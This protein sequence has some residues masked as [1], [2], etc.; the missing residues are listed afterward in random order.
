MRTVKSKKEL[1]LDQLEEVL[2][3]PEDLQGIAFEALTAARRIKNLRAYCKRVQIFEDRS[4]G[5]VSL[6]ACPPNKEGNDHSNFGEL[7]SEQ[8]VEVIPA[9]RTTA[10]SDVGEEILR[11]LDSAA[12]LGRARGK[13]PRRGQQ[14]VAAQIRREVEAHN[15]N[16]GEMGQGALFDFDGGGQA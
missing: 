8:R 6:D 4:C 11:T 5:A 3:L 16:R 14:I 2:T 9:S 15:F 7:L 1:T 13:T 12:N 10:L